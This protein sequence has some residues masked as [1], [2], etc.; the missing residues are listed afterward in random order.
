MCGRLKMWGGRGV[1]DGG[2]VVRMVIYGGNVKGGVRGFV[3]MCEGGVF[4]EA[5][6]I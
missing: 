6:V 1:I 5:G 2:G 3:G 4:L